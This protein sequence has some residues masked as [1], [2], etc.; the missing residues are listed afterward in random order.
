MA[1][2]N[3]TKQAD[4]H[5]TIREIDFVTRF[6]LNWE[7]LRDILGI[8]R[9]I[10]KTP[11]TKLTSKYAEVTLEPGNVGEG[12]V[13]PYSQAEVR[14]KEYGTI[15]IEKY[16]KAVSLEAIDKYGYENAVQRTDDQFLFELQ[17]M[18]TG[19]FYDFLKTGSLILDEPTFQMALA[20]AQGAVR[21][22]WKQMHRSTT[23]IVGF[24]NILDLYE[25]LGN[26]QVT[27][28]SM[29]G[30]N[31]IK[32]F[33]GYETL[34]LLSDAE[35][36][37]GKVLA[38]PAENIILYYVDP[39]DSNFARA[40]L[41]YTTAGGETN[42]IGFH[43]EGDYHTAVSEAFAIMGMT[44]MCEY[45]DGIA[46]VDIGTATFTAVSNPSGNPSALKYFEKAADN[47][48][49]RTTDT[50]VV[51]GKTYYTRSLAGA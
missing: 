20:M 31:Y 45:L 39:S 16:A 21:N 2:E 47:T 5:I 6:G 32:N 51:S 1:K 22:R 10:R 35:I 33:L 26:A 3:L 43:V 44:M 17:N 40:G 27:V 49:F 36:P 7:H 30:L 24:C 11:G 14:E 34:F 37:R 48:Y 25:Y 12:E 19:R 29:F 9:P 50:T 41:T 28:Q 38:T 18:V 46:N 4:I 13:I 15:A 8:M 23:A 42:L